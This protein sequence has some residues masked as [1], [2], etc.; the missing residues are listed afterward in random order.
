MENDTNA[1]R[2]SLTYVFNHKS[3]SRNVGFTSETPALLAHPR[4]LKWEC[5]TSSNASLRAVSGAGAV[6]VARQYGS[7][8]SLHEAVVLIEK[9]SRFAARASERI[10]AVFAS[11]AR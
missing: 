6:G 11:T 10:T 2:V 5:H 9:G 1:A 4:H 3:P 7:I 8:V